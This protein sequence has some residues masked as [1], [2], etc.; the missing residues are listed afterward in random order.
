MGEIIEKLQSYNLNEESYEKVLKTI[1]DKVNGI[2]D[3]DWQEI[4]DKY[5]IKIDGKPI[6]RDTLRKSSQTIFGAG[7]VSE[8][9]EQKYSKENSGLSED[10]YFKELEV[11]KREMFIQTQKY[12][13]VMNQ[14]KQLQREQSRAESMNDIIEYAFSQRQNRQP[15][16]FEKIKQVNDKKEVVCSFA[17]VH[18]GADFCIKG[19]NGEIIN[20]YNKDVVKD[21]FN[22][23]Y[24]ELID[25]CKLHGTNKVRLVDLGDSIEGCLHLSQLRAMKSDIVDDIIDYADLIVDF[26]TQLT[27]EGLI[28]DMYTSQG[29]HG[30]L[31]L[32]TG[33]KGDFPHENLEKIYSKWLE[34]NMRN[35]P[36][37]TLHDNLEGLNYFDVLGYKFLSAHGQDERN[38]KNSIDEYEN[39]YGIN[40]NYFLVGHLHSKFEGDISKDK[41]V[42]QVRSVMGINEYS[43]QIKKTSKAGALMFTVEEGKGKKHINEVVF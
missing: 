30:D 31:R 14:Y 3:I 17:D 29:N 25:F 1:Q 11:K 26:V 8:Y 18:M 10:E 15:V 23:L 5:D 7:F 34:R 42:I 19:F 21:R 43:Q 28:I 2:E 37:F 39:T 6:H 20:E 27:K 9:L 12:R 16:R 36:N 41:E 38:I 33:K 40:I 13:D 22:Q 4:I 35:N 24:N 32:L